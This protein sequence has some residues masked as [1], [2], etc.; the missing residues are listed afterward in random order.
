[1]NVLRV[2]LALVLM[3]STVPVFAQTMS[4]S[5]SLVGRWSGTATTMNIRRGNIRSPYTLSIERVDG[6]KVYGTIDADGASGGFV[7]TL[8]GNQLTFYTG[9]FENLLTVSGKRMFGVRR[10][11]ADIENTEIGLDKVEAK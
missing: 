6:G 8:R 7:G 11:G 3:T 1:M 9:R 5:E 4:D 2:A 10:G